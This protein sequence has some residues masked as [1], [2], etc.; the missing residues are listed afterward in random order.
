MLYANFQGPRPL[1]SGEQVFKGVLFIAL[2]DILVMWPVT[3]IS[4]E[5]EVRIL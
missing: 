5:G 4:T 3:I 1:G 2:M